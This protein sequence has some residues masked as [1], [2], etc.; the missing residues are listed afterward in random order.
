MVRVH[1]WGLY[2]LVG[3]GSGL[4][5]FRVEGCPA[6]MCRRTWGGGDSRVQGVGFQLS[7]AAWVKDLGFW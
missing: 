1:Y 3:D 6:Q 5:Q 7:E 4:P 2:G